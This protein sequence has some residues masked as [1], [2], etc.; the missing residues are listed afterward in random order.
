VRDPKRNAKLSR[1]RFPGILFS[2]GAAVSAAF[3]KFCRRHA[4]LYRF[5]FGKL[6]GRFLRRRPC[7][8]NAVADIGD[9]G[10]LGERVFVK[11]LFEKK[12]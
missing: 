3:E 9:A 5:T 7:E 8:Q 2:V 4:C 6:V 10:I 11:N 12:K 1:S